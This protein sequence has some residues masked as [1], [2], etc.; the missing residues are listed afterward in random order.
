L[1]KGEDEGEG[2]FQRI[3]ESYSHSAES[4]Q[5][6]LMLDFAPAGLPRSFTD[7]DASD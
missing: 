7:D 6:L 2:L 5:A 3:Y 4:I 1:E